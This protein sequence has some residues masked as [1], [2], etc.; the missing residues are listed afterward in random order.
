MLRDPCPKCGLHEAVRVNVNGWPVPIY[1]C[2]AMPPGLFSV[3]KNGSPI[4]RDV[5]SSI[6]K[7]TV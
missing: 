5:A 1:E 2:P 3:L 4:V 6:A 7:E